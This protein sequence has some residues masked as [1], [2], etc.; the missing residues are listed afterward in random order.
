LTAHRQ[1]AYTQLL[2]ALIT[3]Q[4]PQRVNS[5][6]KRILATIVLLVSFACSQV[7]L[8][9]AFAETNPIAKGAVVPD[10]PATAVL[11]T[12]GGKPISV[13]GLTAISGATIPTGATVETPD[14]VNATISF[15]QSQVLEIAA[16]TKFAVDFDEQ[17]NVKVLLI[18]GCVTLRMN[19]GASGEIDRAGSVVGKIDPANGGVL[20][21]CEKKDGWLGLGTAA[22]VAIFGGAT[23]AVV[24][25]IILHGRNPSPSTP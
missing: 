23:A 13:N 25:P 12:K 8:S 1:A 18:H 9:V 6:S 24:I 15:P 5:R 17:G 22:D 20:S 7:Y 4:E 3:L 19:K 11:T 2:F 10:G 21:T 16:K 14:H